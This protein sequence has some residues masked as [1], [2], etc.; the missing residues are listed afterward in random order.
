MAQQLMGVYSTVDSDMAE[1]LELGSGNLKTLRGQKKKKKLG[2]LVN[3]ARM[4]FETNTSA[5]NRY[6]MVTENNTGK[7]RTN[8]TLRRVRVPTLAVVKE[9]KYYEF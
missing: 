1:F 2:T 3:I 7:V 5:F 4:R 8:L 6:E 9:Y